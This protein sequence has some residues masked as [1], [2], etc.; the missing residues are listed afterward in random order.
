MKQL[1]KDAHSKNKLAVRQTNLH[2]YFELAMTK[3]LEVGEHG[4]IF[5]DGP[6]F[7]F[8]PHPAAHV[9]YRSL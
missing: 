8:E 3:V 7:Q 1:E 2:M 5:A 4:T 6:A 9:S